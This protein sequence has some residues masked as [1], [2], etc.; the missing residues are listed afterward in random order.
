[1]DEDRL[2]FPAAESDEWLRSSGHVTEKRVRAL[3][4]E[5]E[6]H[7]KSSRM[8][9]PCGPQMMRLAYRLSTKARFCV[10]LDAHAAT[11]LPVPPCCHTVLT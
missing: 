3:I 8:K 4:V 5:R 2:P 9:L 6:V 1:M 11:Q 10:F 7:E